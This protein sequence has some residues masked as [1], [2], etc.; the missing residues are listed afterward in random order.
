MVENAMIEWLTEPW[1]WGSFM[2]RAALATC[3][4]TVICVPVG[5]F[6]YLRRLSLMS[7]AMSHTV[8]PGIVIAYLIAGSLSPVILL[9]GAA[10]AGI[11]AALGIARLGQMKTIRPD[12]AMATVFTSFF[13][14]GVILLSTKARHAHIDT[15]C[16]LFG[17]VLGITN[18]T[19]TMLAV[20][21]VLITILVVVFWRYL[22]LSTFDAGF[23]ASLGIPV[24]ALHYGL[25]AAVSVG[26]VASF[27]AVG[28]VLVI[29]FFV[30]PA[31]TAHQLSQTLLSMIGYA[32]VVSI[33]SAVIGLYASVYLNA[34][35]AGAIVVSQG[36]VYFLVLF[37]KSSAL[38]RGNNAD[39]F[40]RELPQDDL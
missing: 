24:I 23:S 31:A 8:L 32:F 18:E 36:F 21:S 10:L 13:A 20:S 19:L 11:L 25:M 2:W 35:T 17:N 34:S 39:R 37:V 4:V 22:S 5:V 27:E 16:V 33:L 6:L 29:A 28:A 38:R 26:A 7:D 12:A 9:P 3:L 40:R 1:G 14:L 15:D 30:I